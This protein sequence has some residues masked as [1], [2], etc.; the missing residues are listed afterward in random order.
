LSFPKCQYAF[1]L[2]EEPVNIQ[3]ENEEQE[4][5]IGLLGIYK[6]ITGCKVEDNVMNK[7]YQE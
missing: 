1:A 3:E 6:D 5:E 2:Q 4:G 7:P